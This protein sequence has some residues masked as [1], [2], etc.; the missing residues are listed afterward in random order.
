[1]ECPNCNSEN[2]DVVH[3][4]S[5]ICYDCGSTVQINYGVCNKCNFTFRTNNDHYVDGSIVNE[6]DLAD[7]VEEIMEEM[8]EEM[9]RLYADEEPE[10]MSDL[11]HKCIKCGATA[12]RKGNTYACSE[13][14]FEWEILPSAG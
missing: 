2:V 6:A 14:D 4:D 11:I 1:M 3:G 13:C 12:Y 5:F 8:A 7:F 10:S 9:D